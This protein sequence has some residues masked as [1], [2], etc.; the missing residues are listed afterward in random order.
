MIAVSLFFQPVYTFPFVFCAVC[1]KKDPAD[2]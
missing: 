1:E 2:R